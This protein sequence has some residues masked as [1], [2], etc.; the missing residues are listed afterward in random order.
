MKLFEILMHGWAMIR[1]LILETFTDIVVLVNMPKF[2]IVLYLKA[3][4]I[5]VNITVIFKNIQQ[6]LFCQA[7]QNRNYGESGG[8]GGNGGGGGGV[9]T[10]QRPVPP[11]PPSR[12]NT[13]NR[14]ELMH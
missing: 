5:Y 3:E 4:K 2:D 12:E 1:P 13:L 8:G 9:N 10:L 14:Y 7:I 11:V 6:S